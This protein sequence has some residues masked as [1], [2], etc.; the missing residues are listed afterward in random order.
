MYYMGMKKT[1]EVGVEE[2][3]NSE[4]AEFYQYREIAGCAHVLSRQEC[5]IGF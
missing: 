2:M 1:F 3:A 4:H 5:C